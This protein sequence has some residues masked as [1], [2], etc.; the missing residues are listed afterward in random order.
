MRGN[1]NPI[2]KA[3][4]SPHLRHQ[5]VPNKKLKHDRKA[6]KAKIK[7]G[8][9]D[10]RYDLSALFSSRNGSWVDKAMENK[11]TEEERNQVR[12]DDEKAWSKAIRLVSILA[13]GLVGVWN[14]KGIYATDH[15]IAYMAIGGVLAWWVLHF[16]GMDE[17]T[18]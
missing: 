10:H 5:V 13:G 14:P 16:I 15:V 3:L 18:K 4:R 7:L 2:A 17:T 9:Y 8:K 6:A 11:M 12:A 1:R